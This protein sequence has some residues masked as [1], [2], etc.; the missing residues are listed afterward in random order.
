[1]GHKLEQKRGDED[2]ARRKTRDGGLCMTMP[3]V[4]DLVTAQRLRNQA[5]N[6]GRSISSLLRELVIAGEAALAQK[7]ALGEA[8]QEATHEPLETT[9]A[10]A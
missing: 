5:W 4:V 9:N 7:A 6:E 8:A 1:M 3:V 10:T 2:M